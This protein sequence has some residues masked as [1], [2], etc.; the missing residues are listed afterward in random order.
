MP[1]IQEKLERP[2]LER[3]HREYLRIYCSVS[4]EQSVRLLCFQ[5]FNLALPVRQESLKQTARTTARTSPC[6]AKISNSV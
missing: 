1:P 3:H 4:Y 2:R 6:G 5:Y